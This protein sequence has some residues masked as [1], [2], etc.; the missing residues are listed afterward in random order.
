MVVWDKNGELLYKE[1]VVVDVKF[2]TKKI[3]NK[4]MS[5]TS[6]QFNPW[7]FLKLSLYHVKVLTY[8]YDHMT[9][10]MWYIDRWNSIIYKNYI[11]IYK[12]L[13]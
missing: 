2:N 11:N 9:D 8:D 6:I 4:C 1:N 5:D 3:H 12:K 7:I 10:T 13:W